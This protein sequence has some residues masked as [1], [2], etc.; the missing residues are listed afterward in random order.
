L[1]LVVED[2]DLHHRF[3]WKHSENYGKQTRLW[4]KWF[5]THGERLE[6]RDDRVDWSTT[7]W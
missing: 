4:D 3:G 1:E 7:V 2:H 6:T 5:G